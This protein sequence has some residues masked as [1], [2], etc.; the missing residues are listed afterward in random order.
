MI[1]RRPERTLGTDRR[2]WETCGKRER[3]EL[4]GER[5][6]VRGCAPAERGPALCCLQQSPRQVA[7]PPKETATRGGL[8]QEAL[9][10]LTER[11]RHSVAQNRA[12]SH[13]P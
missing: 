1:F 10:G 4:G 5:G 8:A 2:F 6:E 13:L 9:A 7:R 3:T 12:L 11:P